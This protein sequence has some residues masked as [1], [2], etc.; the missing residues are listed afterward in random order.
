M[1]ELAIK[2][3]F[4]WAYMLRLDLDSLSQNSVNK[5]AIGEWS[6][7]YTNNIA[8]FAHIGIARMHTDIGN[9]Q[10]KTDYRSNKTPE[11][12]QLNEVIENL[13]DKQ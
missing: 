13:L 7:N 9:I 10:V 2:K 6:G 11:K 4:I 3:L 1:D 8:M 5:Y 12:N